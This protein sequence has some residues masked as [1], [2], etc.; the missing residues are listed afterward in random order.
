MYLPAHRTGSLDHWKLFNKLG[1]QCFVSFSFFFLFFLFFFSFFFQ[2]FLSMLLENIWIECLKHSTTLITSTSQLSSAIRCLYQH[3]PK[4]KLAKYLLAEEQ[5]AG[6]LNKALDKRTRKWTQVDASCQ[7]HN[8]RTDLRCV[9]KRIR[10]ST[11]KFTRVTKRRKFHAYT[12][13][14]RSTCV[15]LRW[16]A[17]R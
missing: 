12:V 7:N 17:K 4:L 8:F 13:D 10:K 14:L 1:F 15:D 16:V 2:F 11:W 5:L 3:T 6:A 9:A